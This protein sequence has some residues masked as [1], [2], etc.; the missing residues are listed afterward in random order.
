MA[1]ILATIG[2]DHAQF[3][4][5]LS[6]VKEMAARDS[7]D[8]ARNLQRAGD[9]ARFSAGEKVFKRVFG[10]AS[11]AV[12]AFAKDNADAQATL[13]KWSSAGE[14]IKKGIGGDL[15][16]L[17]DTLNPLLERLKQIDE[18]RG[19]LVDSLAGLASGGVFQGGENVSDVNEQRAAA[20]EQAEGFARMR[21]LQEA[22]LKFGADANDAAG[23][24]TAAGAFREQLRHRQE[25]EKIG[26]MADKEEAAAL[27]ANENSLHALKMANLDRQKKAKADEWDEQ[28]R[29][30]QEDQE[31]QALRL[32]G[33][34]R[35][36]DV[37]EAELKV[38]EQIRKVENDSTL[39]KAEKLGRVQ[40]LQFFQGVA[41]RQ[42]GAD[43]DGKFNRDRAKALGGVEESLGRDSV[44]LLEARGQKELAELAGIRLDYEKR[45]AD[46]R[47]ETTLG[48]FEKEQLI[49]QTLEARD[50]I[51]SAT[52]EGQIEDLESQLKKKRAG[53]DFREV[54]AGIGGAV[55]GQGLSFGRGRSDGDKDQKAIEERLDKL[56]EI[57][58]RGL[59]RIA[60]LL[61]RGV[62]A[63]AA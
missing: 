28:K 6:R 31:V 56:R 41:G 42:A 32:A 8:I 5:G 52:I 4:R 12:K 9:F 38:A 37:M 46:I 16:A 58:S 49:N 1:D 61:E 25:L 7:S 3:K 63:T 43:F 39:S 11:S 40:S 54:E 24:S 53:G 2:L 50:Q 26:K 22:G 10:F 29:Q 47:E 21:R 57:E 62:P 33:R 45:I 30:L 15:I 19:R 55:I 27:L 34:E 14:G 20:A 60:N 18:L 59:D 13:D 17:L 35:E 44:S 23:N 48:A 36:A 51:L